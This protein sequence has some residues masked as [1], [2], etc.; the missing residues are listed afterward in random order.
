MSSHSHLSVAVSFKLSNL[1]F[2]LFL[3]FPPPFPPT[4][5]D[6]ARVSFL[7]KEKKKDGHEKK[8]RSKKK[9]KG[10]PPFPLLPDGFPLHIFWWIIFFS[11]SPLGHPVP[12]LCL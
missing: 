10:L 6:I 12:K 1:S 3:S 5:A 4:P 11:L 8:K 7:K 2:F 9:K